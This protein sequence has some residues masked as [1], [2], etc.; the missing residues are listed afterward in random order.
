MSRTK[1]DRPYWVRA[2]DKTERRVA[3]H[4][5]DRIGRYYKY[6]GQ[7]VVYQYE[8]ECTIDYPRTGNN[9]DK[10]YPC[11]WELDYGY[12]YFYGGMSVQERHMTYY[13]P[14]RTLERDTLRKAVK[15]Y[16]TTG[17][18]EKDIFFQDR[19]QHQ[20]LNGGYWD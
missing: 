1:K 16:N 19:H 18:I 7:S 6:Y 15:E 2:N 14:L 4:D 5:H 17:D 13:N 11:T 12:N 8:D 9:S 3:R 10:N 20:M